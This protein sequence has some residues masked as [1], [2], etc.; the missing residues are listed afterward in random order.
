MMSYC[1]WLHGDLRL[2]FLLLTLRIFFIMQKTFV[3]FLCW[4][5][6]LCHLFIV[7]FELCCTY[8]G[9]CLTNDSKS[10]DRWR[11]FLFSLIHPSNPLMYLSYST[12]TC[13][14]Q[15]SNICVFLKLPV[16]RWLTC[17]RQVTCSSSRRCLVRACSTSQPEAVDP[18]PKPVPLAQYSCWSSLVPAPWQVEICG[19]NDRH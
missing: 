17:S 2:Q 4:R 19:C 13:P 11:L 10:P 12:T 8:S 3:V 16:I 14:E 6:V 5:Q 9:D 15:L 1:W 18:V 7:K